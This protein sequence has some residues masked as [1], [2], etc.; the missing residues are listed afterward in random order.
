[1]CMCV[2]GYVNLAETYDEKT[3][4]QILLSPGDC[5]SRFSLGG[6]F[7]SSAIHLA[8]KGRIS[9]EHATGFGL[10]TGMAQFSYLLQHELQLS[11]Q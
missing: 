7:L 5:T 8:S 11:V 9:D 2:C 6:V 1:M 10:F 4:S 3:H